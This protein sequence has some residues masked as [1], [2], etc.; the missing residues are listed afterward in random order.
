[1][2]R[3]NQTCYASWNFAILCQCIK[4]PE[5]LLIMVPSPHRHFSDLFVINTIGFGLSII[6]SS[7][8]ILTI[9][10]MYSYH[11]KNV[12]AWTRIKQI[13]IHNFCFSPQKHSL[14][15]PDIL[16]ICVLFASVIFPALAVILSA[17]IVVAVIS[18][19]LTW[20]KFKLI[21][22]SYHTYDSYGDTLFEPGR[23]VEN[24]NDT[25]QLAYPFLF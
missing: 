4:R 2:A 12:N 20:S 15:Q 7:P 17:A 21:I 16:S 6:C 19:R 18:A 23:K 22:I 3:N 8:M 24:S 1:M 14:L 13:S 11:Q 9:S 5:I 10:N 25:L